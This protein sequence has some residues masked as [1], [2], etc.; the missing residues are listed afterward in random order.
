MIH[1][2][3]QKKKTSLHGHFRYPKNLDQSLNDVPADKLRKYHSDYNNN[4]T[5]G[6]D[7][8]SLLVVRLG[9]YI[10]NL[11]EFYSY[12]LIGLL[13]S[14]LG[15]EIFSPRCSSSTT[16]PVYVRRVDSSFL[17]FSLSSHRYSCI[18]LLFNS[19]FIDS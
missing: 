8:M 13:Y 3:Q 7:F 6:V 10:V 1:N 18:C 5:R 14:N 16:N 4:P 11:S 2:K 15:L 9:G 17:V 12:R 19:H